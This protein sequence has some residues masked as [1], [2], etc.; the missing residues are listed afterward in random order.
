M[1]LLVVMRPS[2]DEI[3]YHENEVRYARMMGIFMGA[4]LDAV[5]RY[6]RSM[7]ELDSALVETEPDMVL[8]GIDHLPRSI[9]HE[10]D[11]QDESA[12][13]NIHEYFEDCAIPYIGQTPDV[14]ELAL[15]K[16][17]LKRK[18]QAA[19]VHT[20]SFSV[21][22]AGHTVPADI[23]ALTD[24]PYLLK[25]EN[26]GN[27]KLITETSIAYSADDIGRIMA[28][29]RSEYQGAVLIEHYLGDYPDV[30]EI[31]C[32]MIECEEAMVCMPMRL[33]FA[34]PKTHH[35]ITAEDKDR[36]RT[37][38]TPLQPELYE[39]AARFAAE[40]F[41]A[42]GVRDY[43]RGDFFFAGG[44]FHAIEINGQPMIPDRWFEGCARFSG[45]GEA[46]YLVGIV[47][48]G[49]ERLR[50]EGRLQE[51]LPEGA[52]ALLGPLR[53]LRMKMTGDRGGMS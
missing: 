12:I 48:A 23:A 27:S 34:V 8:C 36:H 51:P 21:V 16:A 30:Q 31:T 4:G 42:A 7:E 13:V 45:L 29:L 14:I 6:A 22:P 15:S 10:Q 50:R 25:P 40:A 32:A 39:A 18:W 3:T 28:D 43:A 53:R 41:R 2:E 44:A 20:P 35:L 37:V 24:F 46:Q 49:W 11:S 9:G 38:I 17:A 26:L 1:K 47:A 19:G 33:G 5:F 52:R